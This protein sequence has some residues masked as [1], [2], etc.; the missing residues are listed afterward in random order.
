MASMSKDARKSLLLLVGFLLM[1]FA[2]GFS[3]L[4]ADERKVT[5]FENPKPTCVDRNFVNLVK[6]GEII[7]EP[8]SEEFLVFPWSIVAD[9]KGNFYVYDAMMAKI[10]K[11]GNDLKLVKTF[12]GK[13]RGPGEFGHRGRGSGFIQLF[14]GKDNLIYAGDRNNM[15]VVCFDTSGKFIREFKVDYRRINFVC[16]VLDSKGNLYVHTMD[17][18]EGILSVYDAKGEFQHPLLDRK[19]LARGLFFK[20]RKKLNQNG[21]Y[22]SSCPTTVSHDMLEGDR[23]LV[24]FKNSGFFYIIKD[25]KVIL[26]R[27]LWPPSALKWYKGRLKGAMGDDIKWEGYFPYFCNMFVDKDDERYFYQHFGRPHNSAFTYIYKF[28]MDGKVESILQLREP[29]ENSHGNVLYKRNGLF[30][31]VNRDEDHNKTIIV[32]KEEKTK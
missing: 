12:G 15:K 1:I 7:E 29:L 3:G 31:T 30:Y 25:K 22:F 4:D 27:K 28:N 13:G 16:P 18:K 17:G 20:L 32:Y 8:D 23:L 9:A 6:V 10:Y 24:Y 14:L 2:A 19:L 26:E 21:F 11:Y 5:I